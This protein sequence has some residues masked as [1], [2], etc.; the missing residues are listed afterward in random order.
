MP[1]D[2]N[3]DQ[4]D[5]SSSN[6]GAV[7]IFS[8]TGVNWNQQSYVKSSNTGS[9]DIFGYYLSLSDDGNTLAVT[10]PGEDSAATDIDGNQE[11]NSASNA[12]AIYL[13]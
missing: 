1:M 13:Y 11:D 3:G 9:N 10:A 2:I 6:S 5:N 8:R 7:Y 4:S 12:G